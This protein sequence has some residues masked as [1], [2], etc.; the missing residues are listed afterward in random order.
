MPTMYPGLDLTHF[1][2]FSFSKHSCKVNSGEKKISAK[3]F[4]KKLGFFNTKKHT[5]L[6]YQAKEL[7]LCKNFDFLIS[8]FLQHKDVD[9]RYFKL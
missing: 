9:H 5:F 2:N 4:S 1:V 3:F 8:I 6:L 7:S